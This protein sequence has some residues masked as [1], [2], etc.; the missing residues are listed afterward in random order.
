MQDVPKIVR[1]RLQAA[2]P[3]TASFSSGNHPDADALTAFAERSLTERERSVV[4]EHMVHCRDCRDIVALALPAIEPVETA[5][6]A[7]ARGWLS[8]P[9]LRWGFAAAG[10]VAIAALGIVQYQKRPEKMATYSPGRVDV[11]AN[12]SANRSGNQA[13]YEAKDQLSVPPA[14]SRMAKKAENLQPPP[15]SALA[16][17]ERADDSTSYDKK[18]TSRAI[19]PQVPAAQP[20]SEIHGAAPVVGG[21]LPHGP[22]LANAWQQSQ[23]N[24]LQ[25]QNQASAPTASSPFAKQQ[26][27]GDLTA[28]LRVPAPSETVEAETQS[29][30]VETKGKNSDALKDLPPAPPRQNE[31]YASARIGKAKPVVA[32]QTATGGAPTS[33]AGVPAP[34]PS[35]ATGGLLLTSSG[36]VLRWTISS[37]GSLQR[38]FDQGITWQAVDVNANPAYFLDTTSVEI[39]EKPSRAKSVEIREKPS[40]AKSKEGSKALKRDAS[41][42]IFRTVAASGADV[43]AGGSGGALYHSSDA[44]SHWT[45][46]TPT[47][48]GAALAGDIVSLEF[49]DTQH[50]K[51]ST[52]TGEIWTTSDAG[53][54]WQKQ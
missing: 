14:S 48:S 18:S 6:R 43:W 40:R 26:A 22:R 34:A 31:E 29:A 7:P 4:L 23:Q 25:N 35:Q 46:V 9:V 2:T 10:V 50:G 30:Q 44:G 21:A 42:P 19:A 11:A 13:A 32:G 20:R 15:P 53:Q 52:S 38:S 33:P 17:S 37:T 1:E 45:H 41:A 49:P 39:R 47:S 28:N 3:V 12:E 16:D 5:T 51:V 27:A 54:T 24:A 36:P 8:W